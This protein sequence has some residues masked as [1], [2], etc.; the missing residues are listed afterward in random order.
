LGRLYAR[1]ARWVE[2]EKSF[3]VRRAKPAWN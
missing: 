3:R 1:D 2:S